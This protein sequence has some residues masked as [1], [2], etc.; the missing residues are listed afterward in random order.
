MY[1]LDVPGVSILV[2]VKTMEKRGAVI[3]VAE[4]TLEFTKVFPGTKIPLIQGKNKHLLWDLCCDWNPVFDQK[5]GLTC[6][7][8]SAFHMT[9]ND[10]ECTEKGARRFLIGRPRTKDASSHMSQ[11]VLQHDV[12]VV[13]TQS[14]TCSEESA[15]R[16]RRS[17]V[18]RIHP[19]AKIRS[20]SVAA[21]LQHSPQQKHHMVPLLIGM[22]STTRKF[23][24][25]NNLGNQ[26]THLLGVKS[27]LQS[28]VVTETFHMF[29]I[30]RTPHA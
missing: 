25:Q 30:L 6:R 11:D 4:K 3:R 22:K 9:E 7:N 8:S 19:P 15:R 24:P 17:S 18:G 26:P 1:S 21:G 12:H 29:M 13:E 5:E 28:P 14:E 23:S 10:N 2:G 16:E 20:A 27:R